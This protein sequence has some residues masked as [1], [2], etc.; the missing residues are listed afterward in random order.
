LTFLPF[1]YLKYFTRLKVFPIIRYSSVKYQISSVKYPV[2]IGT[3]VAWLRI[4]Y[5]AIK[6][7]IRLTS[8]SDTAQLSIRMLPC[9][10]WSVITGSPST[11]VPALHQHPLIYS[12]IL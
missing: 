12:L 7:Q 6:Y 5:S 9:V 4:K 3:D 1:H 11:A 8:V 10:G 2:Q